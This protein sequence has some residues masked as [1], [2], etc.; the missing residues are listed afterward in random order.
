[1]RYEDFKL[2]QKDTIKI[3]TTNKFKGAESSFKFNFKTSQF[4]DAIAPT[5]HVLVYFNPDNSWMLLK[6][7]TTLEHE[8]IHFNIAE[9]YARKMRKSIDSL[10]NLQVNNL[11]IYTE[12][13]EIWNKRYENFDTKFD[14]EIDDKIYYT[15]GKY[16]HLDNKKQKI[17]KLKI[18]R[19]LKSL[20]NFNQN[21]K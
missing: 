10:N 20:D 5:I 21:T 9:L 16:L 12:I 6:D 1:M 19:E 18:D 2:A 7:P 14:Q 4:S 8:Q 15:G 11:Q 17:W 13:I 3:A